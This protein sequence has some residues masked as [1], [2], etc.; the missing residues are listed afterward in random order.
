V[1]I[2]WNAWALPFLVGAVIQVAVGLFTLLA[3]PR[4]FLN[5]ALAA[6]FF[7]GAA[8][9]AGVGFSTLATS[10][11]F[12]YTATLFA[13]I[14][15][16]L[17]IPSYLLFLGVALETPLVRPLRSTIARV[18][19]GFFTIG[20]PLL[21][22]ARPDL[23]IGPAVRH[24]LFEYGWETAV[25][26]TAYDRA[27]VIVFFYGLVAAV[28]A[29]RRSASGTPQRHRSRWFMIAFGLRDVTLAG[30]IIAL[31]TV[32]DAQGVT[33]DV[34][35]HLVLA[36]TIILFVLMVAYGILYWD[37]FDLQIQIKGTLRRSVLA[38]I[39]LAI[40]FIV[41]EVAESFL[42]G[43]LGLVA[44]GVAAG[45]LLFAMTPLQ[46]AAQ[47]LANAA[48]PG[49]EETEEY[50]AHRRVEIY[51]GMLEELAVDG[52]INEKERAALGRLQEKLGIRPET[53]AA[54]ERDV[55]AARASRSIAGAAQE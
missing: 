39:F 30:F 21:A 2:A 46:R 36:P 50:R 19:L 7:A 24:V 43:T 18:V 11:D 42:S 3:R 4:R 22:L 13:Q 20:G 49:V 47:R 17:V 40:F 55:S 25:L 53:A 23:F 8:I 34:L 51:K 9:H 32:M 48:M 15:K 12:S 29:Y 54:L 35:Y 16:L 52:T 27:G 26:G 38:G 45:L 31:G 6:M 37:L 28:S 5:R 33:A 1:D 44:G 41:S 10:A 14:G